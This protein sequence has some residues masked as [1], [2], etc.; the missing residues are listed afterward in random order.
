MIQNQVELPV[1]VAFGVAM[2]GMR[3]RFGRSVVTV[4]GVVLGIAFLMAILTEQV[5]SEGVK[6]EEQM[7]MELGRMVGFLT[8]DMGP[9]EG[10]TVSVVQTGGLSIKERRLLLLLEE[11]GLEYTTH[12]VNIGA[13]EQ[14]APDFLAISPNKKNPGHC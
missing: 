10:R 12:S 3:I 5:V 4:M 2:Q 7:R 1:K 6:D 11:L 9:V 14:F 8:A 13:D